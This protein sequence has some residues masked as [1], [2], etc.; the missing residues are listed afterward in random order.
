MKGLKHKIVFVSTNSIYSGSEVLMLN[1]ARL[2]SSDLDVLIFTNYNCED[3]IKNKSNIQYFCTSNK[4]TFINKLKNRVLNI[5]EDL[6][7]S[8]IKIKPDVVI[9]SQGSPLGSL[10]E[11]E[12]CI[13]LNLRFIVINQLV[14]EYHWSQLTDNLFLKLQKAYFKAESVFFV[15]K[16]NEELFTVMF[17]ST[18]VPKQIN[19][20]VAINYKEFLSYPST[21]IFKIAF[22]GRIEFYHK[23]LDLLIEVLR[24]PIWYSR[25]VEFNFYG[26]GPHEKILIDLIS[27]YGLKFCNVKSHTNDLIGVWSENHLAILPSRFEGKSLSISEAMSVGRGVIATN[28]GGVSEQIEDCVSGFICENFTIE[29]LTVTL[30]RAWENRRDW[31]LIGK[32]ARDKF[33]NDNHFSPEEVFSNHLK[34]LLLNS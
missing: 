18:F 7:L 4:H 17:G 27:R 26:S 29:S 22:V 20:P 25:N 14:C 19:N 1:T 13:Q 9:I 12:I 30:E 15:S 33:L 6:K 11:M 21:N 24:N 23:G 34:E 16:Q 28:V 3:F 5:I 2:L 32:N 10:I 8:L 31:E